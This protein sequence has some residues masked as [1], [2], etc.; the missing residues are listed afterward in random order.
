[1]YEVEGLNLENNSATLKQVEVDY[2]TE[3]KKSIEI[4]KLSVNKNLEKKSCSKYFG[5]VMVTT[6]VTGYRRIRWYTNEILDEGDLELPA[7]QLRTT[8][9][10]IS[11]NPWTVDQLRERGQWNSD[12]NNYGS[13]WN[14]IRKLVLQR[15]QYMCQSCGL[16]E[17]NYPFHVHHKTPFR[18]FSSPEQANQ[19]EN[20]VTLCPACH[21]KAEVS[22]LIR[23]G[24]AGLSYVLQNLSPLFVMCD[25]SD[26]GAYHDPLSSLVEKQPAVILFDLVPAGIG[27]S[28][29][30]YEIQDDLFRNALELISICPCQNGCPS[31][32]GPAGIN[33][34]GGKEETRALLTMLC[35]TV[36]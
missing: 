24:L 29:A 26:L 34:I 9:Y 36:D 35:G 2:F 22:I 20:L 14:R 18:L 12:Q 27:L 5:E 1:M 30:L 8:G 11:I 25:I 19:I 23:S 15:D 6:Q 17:T 31:C 3:P 4:E 7:T 33:G 21:R 13:S 28:E 10:W 32:V 16:T